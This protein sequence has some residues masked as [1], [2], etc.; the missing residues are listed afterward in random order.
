MFLEG[1]RLRFVSYLVIILIAGLLAY[2]STY[3]LGMTVDFFIKYS[4]GESLKMLYV[5]AGIIALFGIVQNVSRT[6]LKLALLKIGAELRK[7]IKVIAMTKLVDLE[8][9]WHEKENT[10]SKIQKIN[11]GS[12]SLYSAMM[13][14]QHEG[15]EIIMGIGGSIVIFSL[16]D[17]KYAIFALIY[18][19]IYL[20]MHVYFI[21]KIA[22]IQELLSRIKE[23]V[24]GKVH[25]SASNILAVKSLGLKDNI[26]GKIQSNEEQYYQIWLK[27]RT[28]VARRSQAF[29]FIGS[30]AY[31]GFIIM[32][33]LDAS[34]GI[35]SAVTIFVFASYFGR[36]RS[37]T[38]MITNSNDRIVEIKNG[39]GRMMTILDEKTIERE[40]EH[41]KIFSP[42]WKEIRFE[43]VS[44]KYKDKNVMKDFNLIIKRG[45]KIGVVGRS[46]SGKSTL[47]KLLLGL[48]EPQTGSILLD[49]LPIKE[50]KQSSIN[51]QLSIVLQDSE[52][53]NM[54]LAENIGISDEKLE[55]HKL[56][57]AIRASE[58]LPI[59]K[60]LPQ[61]V[62]TL[63][64]EKGYK[65]SGGE[66]QRVGIARA[67]YANPSM[68]I[69]DEA[70]S[71]LDSKTENYI[72][73]NL[74]DK[75]KD[76]TLLVIAHRLSTLKNVDRIIVMESGKIIEEGKFDDLVKKRGL[77]YELYK[78]QKNR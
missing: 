57:L 27:R 53:F 47:A 10:G 31:G 52:M 39:L 70:T 32:I 9:K 4:P 42:E 13:L 34:I 68:L 41:L 66:R 16:L 25:E 8:L 72:Q 29:N 49:G 62:K 21:K 59:V 18:F 75:L 26:T 35:I 3:V 30:I 17:L 40:S 28:L 23:K 11:N 20:G 51:R 24:S 44:F 38:D 54:T 33:G 12:E 74:R 7:K 1:Y 15:V 77:F 73:I 65:L 14:L 48:Y 45:D 67:I 6:N 37:A 5:Y 61:G 78:T 56:D 46:G 69:L 71:H 58:L 22:K 43:N 36:L 60:K 19:L 2:A 63:I 50:Y 55:V 64:G 76:K